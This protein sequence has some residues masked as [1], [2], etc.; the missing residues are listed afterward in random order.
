[1][2]NYEFVRKGIQQGLLSFPI[3]DFDGSLNF[4]PNGYKDRIKWFLEHD[5][6]AIF[7]AG[8]TGEFFSLSLDDYRQITHIAGETNQGKKPLIA[9]TGKSIAEAIEMAQIAED[10]GVNGLLLMPP[11]LTE[12]PPNGLMKYAQTILNNTKLPVIYYN[13]ANG[14][15]GVDQI[16]ELAYLCPNLVGIKDGTGNLQQL[17]EII[18]LTRGRLEFIGGVPTAEIIAQAYMAIGVSTYSS[19]VFNFVPQLALRFY[20]AIR[21]QDNTV[22]QKLLKHFFIPFIALRK[23]KIGYGVSLIKSGAKIA[24]RP[25]GNT[26]FPLEMPTADEENS[27]RQIITSVNEILN[28]IDS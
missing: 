7:V 1:M 13:R 3:T 12:C 10:N 6:S 20:E 26:R 28:L 8:G 2:N 27:L 19:A 23:R 22:V 15:L 5:I 14:V 18:Q 17:N 24:Q 11:Y 16:Q 4:D 21:S 9:G 25:G